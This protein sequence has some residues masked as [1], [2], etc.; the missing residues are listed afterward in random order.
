MEVA[1]GK[2]LAGSKFSFSSEESTAASFKIL[3]SSLHKRSENINS[4]QISTRSSE[5][6][7]APHVVIF[8]RLS[9]CP[10]R[11]RVKP[12]CR[13]TA[14]NAPV[15]LPALLKAQPPSG[16]RPH[17]VLGRGDATCSGTGTPILLLPINSS[18]SGPHGLA[19]G[20]TGQPA[21]C[22]APGSDLHQ[23]AATQAP[24]ELGL[25]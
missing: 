13:A 5:N 16:H 23:L 18:S 2:N 8:A 22:S 25:G 12:P 17:L 14:I 1:T 20:G 10:W 7:H 4:K 21:L 19:P 15:A 11:G 24:P 3:V 6:K 9:R